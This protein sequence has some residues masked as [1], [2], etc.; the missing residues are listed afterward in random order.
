MR[1]LCEELAEPAE[2]VPPNPA[3]HA[4]L[5]NSPGRGGSNPVPS[6]PPVPWAAGETDYNA[7]GSSGSAFPTTADDDE[8]IDADSATSS[9]SGDE[10]TL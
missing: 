10:E 9:D 3:S 1:E 4:Y 2:G 7:T 8:D 5:C 6:K